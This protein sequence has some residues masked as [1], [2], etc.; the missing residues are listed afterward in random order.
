MEE[1]NFDEM[2]QQIS[3]LK[4]KL[5][6]QEI[7]SDRLMRET[8]KVKVTDIDRTERMSYAC[9]IFC[10]IIYPLL[11]V[12]GTFSWLFSIATCL[13][14][15]FCIVATIYIHR[16]IHKTNLMTSDLATVA[17]VMD[18]FKKQYDVWL[19]YICPA[20]IIPW[21]AICCYDLVRHLPIEDINPFWMCLPVIVGA[22][23]GLIIGLRYH[24]RAVNAAN[25][26]IEQIEGK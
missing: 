17:R 24:F 12:T 13:M 22:I 7:V 3:I 25:S 10:I 9:G 16:P 23:V 2:R 26:I 19:Y 14:M 11:A 4:N 20:L 6:N 18:R 21:L 1:N 15:L 5:D 8:M